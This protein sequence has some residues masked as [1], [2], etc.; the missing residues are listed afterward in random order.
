MCARVSTYRR[1]HT[2]VSPLFLKLL[3]YFSLAE[4]RKSVKAAL[5]RS[6][7]KRK[8]KEKEKKK[9]KGREKKRR[10]EYVSLG[11]HVSVRCL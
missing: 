3:A 8:R 10:Q 5:A 9:K 2:Q 4:V 6:F 11:I 7:R 1:I